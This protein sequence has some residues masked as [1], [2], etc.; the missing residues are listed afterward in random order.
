MFI[1]FRIQLRIPLVLISLLLGLLALGRL[2]R[3][4]FKNEVL[5]NDSA[6]KTFLYEETQR[7]FMIAESAEEVVELPFLL[8]IYLLDLKILEFPMPK[9][10]FG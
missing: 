5:K 2:G 10:S 8:Q 4:R 9:F 6:R 3:F 7:E 1:C